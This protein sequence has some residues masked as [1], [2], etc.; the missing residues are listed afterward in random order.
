[1]SDECILRPL[2]PERPLRGYAIGG[3]VTRIEFRS[4]VGHGY[5]TRTHGKWVSGVVHHGEIRL[6]IQISDPHTLTVVSPQPKPAGRAGL[7]VCHPSQRDG[8]SATRGGCKLTQR[9]V[10]PSKV[11]AER[12]PH[13]H[14][15]TARSQSRDQDSTH[16]CRLPWDRHR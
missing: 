14:S 16:P 5:A 11:K 10:E 15:T 9:L 12:D 3:V 8:G 13:S 4:N 7:R 6:A 2:V 1:M